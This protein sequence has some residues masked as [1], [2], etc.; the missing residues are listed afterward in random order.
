MF[1]REWPRLD[2]A[3][4][5][6]V[7]RALRAGGVVLVPTLAL[8]EAFSRLADPDLPRDPALAGV[9]PQRPRARVGSAATS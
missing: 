5:D 9:P 6:E 3:R 4:L 7:A 2:P 1:E 8:H